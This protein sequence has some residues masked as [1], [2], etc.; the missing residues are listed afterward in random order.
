MATVPGTVVNL[1]FHGIGIP[2]R[3]LEPD[4]ELYWVEVAQFEELLDAIAGFPSMRIT[5]DDGNASD[6]EQALPALLKR[7]LEAAFFVVAGRLDQSGSV[8]GAGLRELV[9][10]GMAVGSHGMRHRPW[11]SLDDRVLG[12]ELVVAAEIIAEASS[13]A[14]REVACPFGSYDR[15]V[16]R[17]VRQAGFERVYTVDG[18]PARG[19]A[20]LQSRCTIRSSDTPA[21][22]RDLALSPRKASLRATLRATKSFLKRWR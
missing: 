10:A 13:H 12:E 7:D 19:D 16:L 14:V 2:A 11:R 4:E 15:R 17:A 22:I 20:W 3:P 18:G 1:C 9:R 5:F 21:Q 6:V 8:S